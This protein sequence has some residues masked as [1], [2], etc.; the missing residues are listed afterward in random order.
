MMPATI[1]NDL[2]QEDDAHFKPIPADIS[3]D[4]RIDS[5]AVRT[6]ALDFRT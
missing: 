5:P 1:I 4:A 2:E 6:L 3:A